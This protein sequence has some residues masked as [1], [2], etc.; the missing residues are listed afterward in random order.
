MQPVEDYEGIIGTFMA[1]D[2]QG[3]KTGALRQCTGEAEWMCM[4]EETEYGLKFGEGLE[5]SRQVRFIPCTLTE[6]ED[7]DESDCQSVSQIDDWLTATTITMSYI[8]DK[9]DNDFKVS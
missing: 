5:G 2:N 8:N 1:F 9:M 7:S 3:V 6:D 4:R